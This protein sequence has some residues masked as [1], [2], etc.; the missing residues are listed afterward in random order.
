M[1]FILQRYSNFVGNGGA[2]QGVLLDKEKLLFQS[3]TIE[4]EGRSVKVMGE[5]R[6]WAGFYKLA[7]L[8]LENDWTLR[9]R[10][11]YGDW[12][13]FPIEIT[14][15]PQ[16]S[17]V[18]IHV[19]YGEKDTEG[20]ILLADTIGNNT[21]DSGNIASRSMD[22]VKRFY[23]KVYPYLESGGIVNLEIRDENF[24]IR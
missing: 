23:Q 7:I 9:H 6:I 8:R 19:G 18:L 12:F 2:T 15:V 16:F 24:L 5:T 1:D 14:N 3:H 4:D 13:K 10:A 22:A 17:G 21:I 20:C 11:K